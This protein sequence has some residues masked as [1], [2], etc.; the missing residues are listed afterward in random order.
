MAYTYVRIYAS[1]CMESL[2]TSY[3]HKRIIIHRNSI[4]HI[5]MDPVPK[6]D[7]AIGAGKTAEIIFSVDNTSDYIR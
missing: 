6:D 1:T 5:I 7:L 2:Y 4:V 3:T